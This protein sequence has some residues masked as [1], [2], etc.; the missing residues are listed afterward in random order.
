MVDHEVVGGTVA[1][2]K[3]WGCPLFTMFPVCIRQMLYDWRFL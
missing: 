2:Y 3:E 1:P